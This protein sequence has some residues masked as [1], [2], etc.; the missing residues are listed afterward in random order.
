M[1]LMKIDTK[2][3]DSLGNDSQFNDTQYYNI[4]RMMLWQEKMVLVANALAY[5]I[6]KLGPNFEFW[7]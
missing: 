2:Q 3:N 1:T 6:D 7:A 4:I 5:Y